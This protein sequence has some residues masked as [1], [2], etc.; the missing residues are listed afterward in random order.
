MGERGYAWLQAAAM[1]RD[2]RAGRFGE[3]ELDLIPLCI[4]AGDTA[5]DLGANYGMY[6]P[7]MARAVGKGGLVIAFEPVP[8]TSQ[9]LRKVVRLLRLRN[10]VI[11]AKGCG[12]KPGLVSFTV[13]VQGTGA[14]SAGQAHFS[15]RQDERAGKERHVRWPTS[16]TVEAEVV[17]VDDTLRSLGTGRIS[18]LKC[19]IEGA[20]LY[21]LRGAEETLREHHPVLVAEI[22]PWFLEGFGTSVEELVAFLGRFGYRLHRYDQSGRSLMPVEP[23]DVVE[24]NYVFLPATAPSRLAALMPA[25]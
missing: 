24:A 6:L 15:E 19:D 5:L 16:T 20:E 25:D 10:V 17:R 21:A 3:P 9:V 23:A 1:A 4:E 11:V 13:P 2:I 8:F 22:N 12:E 7:E 14:L 18:F